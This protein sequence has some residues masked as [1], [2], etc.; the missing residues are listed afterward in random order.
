[1]CGNRSGIHTPEYRKNSKLVWDERGGA[2]APGAEEVEECLFTG[3][4]RDSRRRVGNGAQWHGRCSKGECEM[5]MGGNK[6]YFVSL[7]DNIE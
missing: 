2:H 3:F 5:I 4:G 1:M 6:R 7:V